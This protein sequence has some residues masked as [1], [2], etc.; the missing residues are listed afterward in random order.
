VVG[1]QVLVA[2]DD[3]YRAYREVI[4]AG[5]QILRPKVEVTTTDL[6][7]LEAKVARLNAQVVISSLNK[8]ASLRAEV[9]WAKVPID[10]VPQSHASLE[11]LLA[12]ID[13]HPESKS[14]GG[15]GTGGAGAKL[16]R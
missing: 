2:L 16:S 9:S 5:I 3:E 6:E 1:I 12:V 10:S 4:A 14:L 8:P 13:E 11:A 7:E 15:P